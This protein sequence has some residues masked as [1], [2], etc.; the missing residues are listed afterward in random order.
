MMMVCDPKAQARCKDRDLCGDHC[1]KEGSDCDKFNQKVL[2]DKP[3]HADRLRSMS[4][5]K[6]AE[7]L[8][9]LRG[10]GTCNRYHNK[11]YP[12]NETLDWLRQPAGEEHDG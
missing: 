5:E 9:G 7:W 10:C 4:D 6:L 3:T 11:Q 1:F 12:I 2:A 8:D